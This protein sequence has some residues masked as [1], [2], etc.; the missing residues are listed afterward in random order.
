MRIPN[1]TGNTIIDPIVNLKLSVKI[2]I[3]DPTKAPKP[4][5]ADTALVQFL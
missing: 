4:V 5:P 1:P 3:D 2:A